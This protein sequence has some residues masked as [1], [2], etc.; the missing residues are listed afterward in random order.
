MRIGQGTVCHICILTTN[1][2]VTNARKFF[3]LYQAFCAT[4]IFL[5]SSGLNV[6]MFIHITVYFSEAYDFHNSITQSQ[7]K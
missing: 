1:S 7:T 2:R 6:Y 4:I 5:G 3:V